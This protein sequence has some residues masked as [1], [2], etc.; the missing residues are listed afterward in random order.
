MGEADEPL[1][2]DEAC[3]EVFRGKIKPAT[4]RAEA[5]R[6][7]L[8]IERI[9]RRD[10]VTRAALKRMRELCRVNQREP[11]SGPTN[12]RASGMSE[13]ERSSVAQSAALLISR[14]L[15]SSLGNTPRRNTSRRQTTAPASSSSRTS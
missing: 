4:L 9:G 6:G 1:T 3:R 2:L 12:S 14:E 7:R 8:E 5:A 10:F 11:V 15:K 13:M